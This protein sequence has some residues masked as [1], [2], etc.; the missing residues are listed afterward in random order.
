MERRTFL[1]LFGLL[2]LP[3]LRISKPRFEISETKAVKGVF[4]SDFVFR[5]GASSNV[6]ISIYPISKS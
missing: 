5:T 6:G 4:L 1:G 3:K 2:G